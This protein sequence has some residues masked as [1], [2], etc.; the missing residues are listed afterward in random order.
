MKLRFTRTPSVAVARGAA[1]VAAAVRTHQASPT[2]RAPFHL[3]L[4][5]RTERRHFRLANDAR[6]LFSAERR[7][8]ISRRTQFRMFVEPS[9][10]SSSQGPVRSVAAV[11]VPETDCACV[12]GPYDEESV[13]GNASELLAA[14]CIRARGTALPRGHANHARKSA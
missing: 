4:S 13:N 8:P 6:Y 3:T 5:G 11:L 7:S 14:E 2:P 12:I 10:G 9:C 1:I